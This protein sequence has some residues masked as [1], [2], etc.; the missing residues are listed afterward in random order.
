MPATSSERPRWR[1]ALRWG[2]DA[3]VL[4]PLLAQQ[5]PLIGGHLVEALIVLARGVP[6]PRRHGLPAAV[7]LERARPLLRRELLP[8]LEVPLGEGPL[9]GRELLEPREGSR[10]SPRDPEHAEH[11]QRAQQERSPRHA[12][13]HRSFAS[14]GRVLGSSV[15]RRS[16]R[17][18]HSRIGRRVKRPESRAR[19]TSLRRSRSSS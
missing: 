2:L 6:L 11:E 17:P 10:L 7:V 9:L 19:S 12:P 5:L 13:V 3:A 14:L 4:L 16:S 18:I 8:A 1:G 15:E